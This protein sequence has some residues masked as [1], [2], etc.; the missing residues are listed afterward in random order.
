[1]FNYLYIKT[2]FRPDYLQ[3]IRC[4]MFSSTTE[5]EEGYSIAVKTCNHCETFSVRV[6]KLIMMNYGYRTVCLLLV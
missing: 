2:S 6:M 1:M 4:W 3:C 5:S